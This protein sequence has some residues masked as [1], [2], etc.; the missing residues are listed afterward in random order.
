MGGSLGTVRQTI[1]YGVGVL[2]STIV[3][4]SAFEFLLGRGACQHSFSVSSGYRIYRCSVAR[5]KRRDGDV[6][7]IRNIPMYEQVTAYLPKIT[8]LYGSG[9]LAGR[10]LV[11]V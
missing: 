5:P 8:P 9:R 2:V 1:V 4:A 10:P 7:A 6:V 11:R 3:H